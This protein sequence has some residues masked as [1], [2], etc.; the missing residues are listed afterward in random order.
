MNS[1]PHQAY[2]PYNKAVVLGLRWSNDDLDLAKPQ[3]AL[4][5]TFRIQCGFE[6][7]SLLIPSTSSEEAL[8]AI[9]QI[10]FELRQRYD[11]DRELTWHMGI[12][13]T[14]RPDAVRIP[15]SYIYLG[16]KSDVLVLIDTS[17]SG[18]FLQPC[19]SLQRILQDNDHHAEYL[20]STGNEISD[21][22]GPTYDVNNNFT[23]RLTDLLYTA[24]PAPVTVVQLHEALCTQANDPSTKLRYTP[25]YMDCHKPS[26]IIQHVNNND[27]MWTVENT[28]SKAQIPTGRALISVSVLGNTVR[29]QVR[30]W[31]ASLST[32]DS[33]V[34]IEGYNFVSYVDSHN[35]LSSDPSPDSLLVSTLPER[36]KDPAYRRIQRMLTISCSQTRSDL[37]LCYAIL[38][39][40]LLATE[41][42]PW[43]RKG[44]LCLLIFLAM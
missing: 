25:Q 9:S 40:Q 1:K 34:T 18:D 13:G 41:G 28:T 2:R 23:T 20:F 15:W 8:N 44:F 38:M 24:S 7:A 26:I 4:L 35:L 17:Y 36:P 39:F 16:M 12:F 11:M 42:Y 3:D 21:Q 14:R 30:E 10:V 6:T 33:D 5:E 31:Q 43:R 22:N 29:G 27:Y 19:H 32:I 37:V